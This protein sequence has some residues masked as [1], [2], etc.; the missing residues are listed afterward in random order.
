MLSILTNLVALLHRLERV[1]LVGDGVC[2]GLDEGELVLVLA[3]HLPP[4]RGRRCHS[5]SKLHN[6]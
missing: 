4:G 1:Q 2:V 6:D 5:R 3:G